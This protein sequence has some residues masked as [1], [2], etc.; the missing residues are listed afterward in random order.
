[1]FRLVGEAYIHD[2]NNSEDETKKP[3]ERLFKMW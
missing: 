3:E 1:M 2:L